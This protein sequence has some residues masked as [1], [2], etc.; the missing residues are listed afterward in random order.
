MV[1]INLIR[2][3]LLAKCSALALIFS[4]YQS[5]HTPVS[6]SMQRPGPSIRIGPLPTLSSCRYPAFW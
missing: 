6:Y 2:V 1:D 4:G 3:G 5:Q